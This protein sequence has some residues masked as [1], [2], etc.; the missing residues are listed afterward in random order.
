ME[1][2][3]IVYTVKQLAKLAGISVRTLHYYDEIGLLRPSQLG[4]NG[5]R[6]YN[7][8]AVLRLQQILFYREIDLELIQIKAILD[9]PD[10]DILTALHSH[11]AALED[12]IGH[13]NHL[14]ATVDRTIKHLGGEIEM[15]K[16]QLFKGF[17]P[18]KQEHYERIA[19]LQYG[20]DIVNESAKLWKSYSEK[21][22]NAIF[23]E[24]DHL[25]S[26]LV[27]ALNA[28]MAP[29]SA[30][31]QAIL[32][33]WHEHLRYFYEPKIE[34]LRG[35]GDLYHDDPEFAANFQKFHPDLPKFLQEAIAL[36]VDDLENAEIARLLAEDN[37]K[38][39]QK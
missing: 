30:E 32:V 20:P 6:Y 22:K 11:R 37:A 23:V 31:V 28:Q 15:S 27:D 33:R 16:K 36:Y 1:R 9:R 3:L 29:S 8:Q 39:V 21:Q 17:S 4:D 34:I 24:G 19:R 10:F 13:L 5:Y 38:K 12:K 26:D 25:Y 18:K 35:L 14:I 2:R 7:D